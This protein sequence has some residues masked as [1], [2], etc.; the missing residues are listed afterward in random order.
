MTD[1]QKEQI[2]KLRSKGA[3][4]TDISKKLKISANSVKSFC[5][6]DISNVEEDDESFPNGGCENCG[7][8]VNQIEGRKKKRFCCDTCRN[9]WWN[10]HLDLVN[11]KSVHSL[12]CPNCRCEFKYYGNAPRKYC[13]HKCYI[14][15]RY[16]G[17]IINGE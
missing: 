12:V 11:R 5:R 13:S 6:R 17:E 10:S 7:R 3:S 9:R 8:P 15:Y 14:A 4:Y 2:R 16:K 1:K